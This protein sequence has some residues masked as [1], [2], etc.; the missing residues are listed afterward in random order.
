VRNP[1]QSAGKGPWARARRAVTAVQFAFVAPVFLFFVLGLIEVGRGI[2]ATH[3]LNSA[4][5]DACRVGILQN[6]TDSDMKTVV[7][8]AMSQA[9]ITGY[10][11]TVYVNGA[12]QKSFAANSNDTIKVQV[13]VPVGNISWVPVERF[14]TG[15][16]TG[17]Y[18]LKRE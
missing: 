1:C 2:M 16:L 12:V 7:A 10:T 4:A 3:E 15:S 17:E 6:K 14:L 18:T 13:Q 9:G 5:R 11:T 8:N